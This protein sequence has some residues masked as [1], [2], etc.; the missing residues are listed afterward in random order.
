MQQVVK[1]FLASKELEGKSPGTIENYK[2]YLGIFEKAMAKE[3]T[4][5]TTQEI[6]QFLID[7]KNEHNVKNITLDNIRRV[8]NSFY[9]WSSNNGYIVFNPCAAVAKV[10][11]DKIKKDGFSEEELDDIREAC[12]NPR[13]RAV[14]EFLYSSGVRVSEMVRLNKDDIDWN[15]R[16]CK[17]FGKGN[18]ERIVYFSVPAKKRL[19]EYLESRTDD[20]P[21]LFVSLKR[22]YD[23][24]TKG[25]IEKSLTVIGDK[26]NC[27]VYPHRFRHTCATTL[28]AKGMPIEEVSKFLGHEKVET[29]MIYCTVKDELIEMNYR[30]IMI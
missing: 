2:M 29:T 7:Y 18:K 24:V 10:K 26:I 20:N 22:P 13:D 12:K 6:R 23:R 17:V 27:H 19:A 28:L 3:L 14:V 15:A 8:L 25:S 1:D 5:V 21:A 16:R 4:E 9:T 11:V 30:K